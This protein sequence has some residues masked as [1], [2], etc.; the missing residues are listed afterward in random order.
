VLNKLP[1]QDVLL[2]GLH[3][4]IYDQNRVSVPVY[5]TD[6]AEFTLSQKSVKKTS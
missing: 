3:N 2:A 1:R 6:P 4:R 5:C